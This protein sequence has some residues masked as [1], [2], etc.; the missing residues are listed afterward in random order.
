MSRFDLS[1]G[2][3]A[4]LIS[5]ERKHFSSLRNGYPL[6]EEFLDYLAREDVDAIAIDDGEQI[7]V[8]DL[9]RYR[10]GNRVGHAPYP[11]KRVVPLDDATHPL[12]EYRK[13]TEDEATE[14]EWLTDQ[15]L[16]P[17]DDQPAQTNAASSASERA[18]GNR[19]TTTTLS[20]SAEAGSDERNA[21]QERERGGTE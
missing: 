14:W 13:H 3:A 18:D 19:G 11:M 2:R 12:D 20:A 6:A 1:D 10:R 17:V 7:H 9:H 8:F 16:Q 21:E 4:V 15:D 5:R